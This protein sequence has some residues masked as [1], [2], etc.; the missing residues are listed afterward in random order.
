M[1]LRACKNFDLL[2]FWIVSKEIALWDW[3][4]FCYKPIPNNAEFT[5]M[6]KNSEKKLF[7]FLKKHSPYLFNDLHIIIYIY[8]YKYFKMSF[9]LWVNNQ[10]IFTFID[11]YVYELH[12]VKSFWK[13]SNG[14]L[15]ECSKNEEKQKICY[16]LESNILLSKLSWL[17]SHKKVCLN[18]ILFKIM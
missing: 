6:E 9:S 16:S 1:H 5:F 10:N 7:C 11:M 13:V 4:N 3:I 18:N 17:S 12:Q 14:T 8:I 15:L 2:P